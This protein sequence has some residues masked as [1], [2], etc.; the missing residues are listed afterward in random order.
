MR[1]VVPLVGSGYKRMRSVLACR[2]ADE[3][4][5]CQVSAGRAVWVGLGTRFCNFRHR[6]EGSALGSRRLLRFEI[7]Q[8]NRQH[9]SRDG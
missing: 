5:L 2:G 3:V 6:H 7:S 1:W 8:I 4:L 9:T